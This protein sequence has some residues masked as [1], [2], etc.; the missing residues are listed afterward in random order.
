MKRSEKC[1]RQWVSSVIFDNLKKNNKM[2]KLDKLVPHELGESQRAQSFE[3]C[4]LEFLRNSYDP[5]RDC[6]M[7]FKRRWMV[8]NYRKWSVQ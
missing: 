4:S 8:Y 6:M 5:F 1:L 7:N 3:V 2:K